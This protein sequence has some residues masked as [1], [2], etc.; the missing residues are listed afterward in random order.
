MFGDVLEY[1]DSVKLMVLCLKI[2]NMELVS[3]QKV[4]LNTVNDNGDVIRAANIS[5]G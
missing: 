4:N 5:I 2:V 3:I 1:S